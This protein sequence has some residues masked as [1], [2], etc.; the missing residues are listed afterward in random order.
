M[1]MPRLAEVRRQPVLS[2]HYVDSENQTQVV[3]LNKNSMNPLSHL[4][5][6]AERSDFP[7]LPAF[8]TLAPGQARD[9]HGKPPL[10]GLC[11]SFYKIRK[12]CYLDN[13]RISS[14]NYL[15]FVLSRSRNSNQPTS[16]IV[17][18]IWF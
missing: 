6:T 11:R 13:V 4:T 5:S 17:Y 8:A 18:I 3:K 10:T 12:I 14:G 9:L 16:F 15:S 7:S 1:S 2:F